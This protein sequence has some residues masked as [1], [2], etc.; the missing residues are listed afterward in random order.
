MSQ[1]LVSAA[2]SLTD[3][4]TELGKYFERENRG[5][6]VRFNFGASGALMAQVRQ[7]APVDVFL[8]ASPSE[9]D[10]LAREDKIF[11]ASRRPV[12]GNRL[13]LIAPKGGRLAGWDALAG[14][15]VRR[16]ALAN[17]GFVPAGRYGKQALVHR[18]LWEAVKNKLVYAQTVRQALAYVAGGDADAGLVFATDARRENRVRVVAT[19]IPGK[20]HTPIVYSVAATSTCRNDA[21]AGKLILFLATPLARGIFARYGFTPPT[22]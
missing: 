17:P 21:L 20:D 11:P 22:R 7:G 5:V 8:S 3:V 13:V 4:L 9:M 18:K 19:A 12:A 2:S 14:P 1:L 6:T 16:I 10:A 15:G